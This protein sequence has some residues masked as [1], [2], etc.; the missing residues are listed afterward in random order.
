MF[1]KILQGFLKIEKTNRQE[2]FLPKI[3]RMFPKNRFKKVSVKHF[4]AKKSKKLRP[5]TAEA[6]MR[7][8]K[9]KAVWHIDDL[10]L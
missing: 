10:P 9:I 4:C 1:P 8:L 6:A 5:S 3:C 2:R 7:I